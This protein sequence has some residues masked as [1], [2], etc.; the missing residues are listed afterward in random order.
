MNNTIHIIPASTIKELQNTNQNNFITD[1]EKMI[2]FKS[3][4]ERIK[5][6]FMYG[7]IPDHLL[8]SL[9]T[10]LKNEVEISIDPAQYNFP[11]WIVNS[12]KAKLALAQSIARAVRE[13]LSVYGYSVDADDVNFTIK[14]SW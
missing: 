14:I 10:D 8:K 5:L 4:I 11:N 1:L 7:L 2:L 6:H 9:S 13:E 12:S 3:A